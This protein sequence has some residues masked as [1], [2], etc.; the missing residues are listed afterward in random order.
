MG[1]ETP[2]FYRAR[3]QTQ[4]SCSST[5]QNIQPTM[6]RKA[7][8]L[9]LVIIPVLDISL[10]LDQGSITVVAWMSSI[11]LRWGKYLCV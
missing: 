3:V 6:A 8:F 1:Q 9:G 11:T 2:T 10:I 4:G 5:V 7:L